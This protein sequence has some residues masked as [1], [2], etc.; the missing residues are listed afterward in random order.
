MRFKILALSG[1]LLGGAIAAEAETIYVTNIEHFETQSASGY[2]VEAKTVKT[3]PL[4]EYRLV[5]YLN[6]AGLQVGG[7]YR[8]EPVYD[9]TGRYLIIYG[10]KDA[11]G[12][13]MRYRI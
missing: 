6:A 9:P 7:S 5:C 3:E 4:I 10:V 1:F 13:V 8:A 12:P 11:E 2:K